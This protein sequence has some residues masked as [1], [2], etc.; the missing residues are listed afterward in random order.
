MNKNNNQ[1]T[2]KYGLIVLALS[3]VISIVIYFQFSIGDVVFLKHYYDVEINNSSFLE[4]HFIANADD[5]RQI[6]DINF[7]QV[8]DNFAQIEFDHFR[9]NKGDGY[10]YNTV[11]TAHYNYNVISLVV[12]VSANSTK[13]D[14]K[15][16]LDK[17]IVKFNNGDEQEVDIGRIVLYKNIKKTDALDLNYYS[18]SNNNISIA[19]MEA[20]KDF[21]IENISSYLDKEINSIL[22]F[23]MNYTPTDELSYPIDIKKGESLSFESQFD[24]KEDDMSKFNVY[25]IQKKVAIKDNNKRTSYQNIYNIAYSPIDLFLTEKNIME[26]LN[27]RGVK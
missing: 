21:L 17:A 15:I 24:F 20:Q 11:K 27:Y 26:Y 2:L 19:V 4:L 7:P 14:G 1:K 13:L 23:K 18:S 12:L 25:E 3:F 10:Y 8:Q 6:T 16:V 9:N 5:E 22:L